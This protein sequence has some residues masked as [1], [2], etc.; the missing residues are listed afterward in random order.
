M[1]INCNIYIISFLLKIIIS[2]YV[3]AGSPFIIDVEDSTMVFACGR[4]LESAPVGERVTF[5]IDPSRALF[6]ADV[7]LKITGKKILKTLDLVV[8]I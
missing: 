6:R 7:Q 4:S 8:L 3:Y 1:Q 5:D 2:F